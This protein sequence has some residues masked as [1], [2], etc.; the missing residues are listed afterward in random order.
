MNPE[1]ILAKLEGA[2]RTLENVGATTLRLALA[3]N[4]LWIGALKFEEYE[5][6][7]SEP[8]I[9]T[10]PLFSW[11]NRKLGLRKTSRLIGVAEIALGSLI[12]AKPLA[13][14]ASAVGSL[15]A[16]AMFSTTL[17]FLF[18]MPG[19]WQEGYGKPRL[20]QPGQFLLKDSVLLGAAL[21]TAAE[22]LR[23]ARRR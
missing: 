6:E 18:T 23:E 20:S 15:G 1:G 22:S 7:L 5:A 4:I 8:M 13:P 2:E 17:S 11:V 10:S 19:V 14:R 16:V 12:A 9:S 3:T 21:L